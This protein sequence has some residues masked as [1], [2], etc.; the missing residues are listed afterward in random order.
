MWYS[1]VERKSRCFQS[2]LPFMG[3]GHIVTANLSDI[4]DNV[5]SIDY[6]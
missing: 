4:I 2:G 5:D 6:R 1:H 3:I